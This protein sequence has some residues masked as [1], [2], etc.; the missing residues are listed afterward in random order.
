MKG[1]LLFCLSFLCGS[2]VYASSGTSS[3][4][5]LLAVM[6]NANFVALVDVQ[7]IYSHRWF[8]T[9]INKD[10]KT[11]E[12]FKKVET[13]LASQG[14]DLRQV[15]YLAVGGTFVRGGSFGSMY[16]LVNGGFER[17]RLMSSLAELK[18]VITTQ[19]YEGSTI[20][21]M[22]DSGVD[23]LGSVDQL[24]GMAKPQRIAFVFLSQDTVC[25]GDLDT[26]KNALDVREGSRR[27]LWQIPI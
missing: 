20:Y 8:S 23:L 15:R 17:E 25:L 18:K 24:K 4:S 1:I 19:T 22:E 11:S 3:V 6:P 9:I 26:V 2:I 21:L 16:F 7:Q 13:L 14:I 5:D 10:P 12:E 27:V